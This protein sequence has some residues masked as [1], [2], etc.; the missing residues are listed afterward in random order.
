[1]RARISVTE[2][3]RD[4]AAVLDRVRRQGHSYL[5]EQDGEAVATLEPIGTSRGATWRT[6]STA[7]RDLPNGDFDFAADLEELQR[8][9][10]EMPDNVWPS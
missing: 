1:M 9:Q 10:P 7:L 6:L 3:G 8:N 4:L 5:I 2:L